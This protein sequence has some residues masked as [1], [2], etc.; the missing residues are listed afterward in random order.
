MASVL[1]VDDAEIIRNVIKV[2]L[3]GSE[4][5]VVAE[6]STGQ[7]ALELYAKLRPDI[8]TLDIRMRD[9]DGIDT[10]KQLLGNFPEARVIM[11]SSHA[12]KE[13]L[14]EAIKAGAKYYLLKPVPRSKLMQAI[15]IVLT[16]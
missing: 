4:H 2:L 13:I 8:V 16:Q 11:I 6:A 1:I 12:E 3:D 10:L 15:D 7:K 9:M 5:H 14:M